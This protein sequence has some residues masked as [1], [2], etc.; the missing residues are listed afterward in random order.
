M[1]KMFCRLAVLMAEKDP[2][3]SQRQLASETGLSPTT[4]HRLFTNKFERVDTKT[5]ETLCSYFD[6][7]I[8]DL[9]VLRSFS[10]AD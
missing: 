8:G 9:F 7:E 1:K 3:L 2:R 6:K 10:E 5:I 4:V